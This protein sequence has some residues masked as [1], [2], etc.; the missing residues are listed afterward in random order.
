MATDYYELLGVGHD[1]SE[2]EIEARLP[3][4]RPRA[5][6]G[7]DRRRPRGGATVQRDVARLRG[8]SR[9]RAKA[10]LRHVR[11]RRRRRAARTWATSSGETSGDLLGAFFGGG[12]RPRQRTGPARGSDAETVLNLSFREAAFG[13]SKE[14]TVDTQVSCTACSGSGARPGTTAT[15]CDALWRCG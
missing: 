15:R 9:S 5:P 8:T 4:A 11:A 6:S 13:A 1:A 7:L 12:A 2:E 10:P 3:P 14:M